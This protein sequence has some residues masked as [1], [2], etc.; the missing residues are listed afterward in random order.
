MLV[1]EHL[2]RDPKINAELQL[3]PKCI[4][5]NM[6]NNSLNIVPESLFLKKI[7]LDFSNIIPKISKKQQHKWIQMDIPSGN[8]T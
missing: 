6:P 2:A 1:P 7:S 5:Q 4:S 3:V 8:L